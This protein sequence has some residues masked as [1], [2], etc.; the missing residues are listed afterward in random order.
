MYRPHS[1]PPE[2]GHWRILALHA[3]RV[4]PLKK[5]K[6]HTGYRDAEEYVD[7]DYDDEENI[8]N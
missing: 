2:E 3:E 1:D 8:R 7:H 5:A 4:K 6:T